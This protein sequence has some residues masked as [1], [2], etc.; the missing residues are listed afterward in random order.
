MGHHHHP[1]STSSPEAQR[2]FD[3]GLTL[4]YA[5]MH[6][7]AARSFQKAADLDPK[8]AMPYWGLA[9][10]LGPNYNVDVDPEHELSAHFAIEKAKGLMASAT[11]NEKAYINALAQRYTN[12]P[13]P[14]F[15]KLAQNYANAMREVSQRYPD[16]LDAAHFMRKR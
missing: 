11:E 12:D 5:F 4:D 15:K 13:K 2:F 9:L 8:A 10:V 6:D 16:D 14:D 1:I 7:E 3:Q